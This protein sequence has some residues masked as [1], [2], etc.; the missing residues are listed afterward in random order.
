MEAETDGSGQTSLSQCARVCLHLSNIKTLTLKVRASLCRHSAM[1]S[2]FLSLSLEAKNLPHRHH[3]ATEVF[4]AFWFQ[5]Y[6]GSNEE[7]WSSVCALKGEF[8]ANE[9]EF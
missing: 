3:D 7:A 2:P 1:I 5:I 9:K 8:V 4:W 6:C